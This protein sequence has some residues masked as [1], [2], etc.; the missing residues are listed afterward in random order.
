[1]LKLTCPHCQTEFTFANVPPGTPVRCRNCKQ[2]FDTPAGP[3]GS[4]APPEHIFGPAKTTVA[5]T[6]AP[7]PAPMSAPP[8]ERPQTPEPEPVVA[9]S[10]PAPEPALPKSARGPLIA[11]SADLC[12][13][14]GLTSVKKR[15]SG[16]AGWHSHALG[17]AVLAVIAV[18]MPGTV[19]FVIGVAV[20]ALAF[21]V[22]NVVLRSTPGY[23]CTTCGHSW[24]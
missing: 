15:G 18:T 3:G 9:R 23:E 6:P 21:L 4:T 8:P 20:W 5:Y 17:I 14:C 22:L 7:A 24:E 19:A 12:P 2:T 16:P 10:E 11:E 13:K 1:M